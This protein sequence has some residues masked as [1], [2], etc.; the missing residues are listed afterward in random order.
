MHTNTFVRR[1]SLALLTA[2]VVSGCAH[3]PSYDPLDPLERANR[4]V[5]TFNAATDTYVIRPI[6]KGYTRIVPDFAR[7]GIR[8]FLSNLFYP[9]VIINDVLQWKWKQAGL[10]TA[11]FLTN[12]T[13]GL[14]GLMDVATAAGMPAHD[15]DFGQTLGY[16]GLGQ[17]WFIMIPLL[18][19]SSNRDLI[20]LGVDCYSNPTI[21]MDT[22]PRLGTVALVTVDTRASLLGTDKLVNQQFDPYAFLRSAYLDRRHNLVHDGSPPPEAVDFDFDFDE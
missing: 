5:F 12:T 4:A 13:A 18:G 15:E 2:A 17:G 1:L 7:S 8:N 21:L 14:G 22:G 11:R 10:D 16:W 3:S 9:T 19:P 6:A 20:G